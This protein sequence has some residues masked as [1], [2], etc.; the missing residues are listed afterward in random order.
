LLAG[1][2]A[3]ETIV[4]RECQPS[5]SLATCY[6]AFVTDHTRAVF[7]SEEQLDARMP[8]LREHH[9]EQ[10]RHRIQQEL[11]KRLVHYTTSTY[12][13]YIA[14]RAQTITRIVALRIALEV[15]KTG[16]CEAPPDL[17]APRTLGD[18]VRVTAHEHELEIMPPAW[19]TSSKYSK[20]APIVVKC[21]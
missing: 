12:G 18:P 14:K 4:T 5:A 16:R 11:T 13:D 20:L 19:A 9:D 21:P 6:R 15:R 10:T 8:E 1:F 2:E 7:D 3:V 17:L